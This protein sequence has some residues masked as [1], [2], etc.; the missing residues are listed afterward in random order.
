M[1]EGGVERYLT[2]EPDGGG[3][4]AVRLEVDLARRDE[5][6]LLISCSFSSLQ[7]GIT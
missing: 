1:R 2:F 6:P 4:L 5:S 3:R 7:A